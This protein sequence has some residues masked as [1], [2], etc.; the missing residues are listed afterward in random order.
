MLDYHLTVTWNYDGSIVTSTQARS[1]SI[2]F[3]GTYHI[4]QVA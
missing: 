2:H 1:H 4:R 3:D